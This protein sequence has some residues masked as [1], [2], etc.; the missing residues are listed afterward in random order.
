MSLTQHAPQPRLRYHRHAYYF[1][2]EALRLA[3][4]LLGRESSDADDD[5]AHITGRELLDGVRVLGLRQF[6]M[7]APVVFAHWGITTTDDFGQIVFEMIERE[8]LRKTER[9]QVS[10]FADVYHFDDVFQQNYQVDTSKA[11]R[12]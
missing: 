3:Q 2:T 11:F 10:D 7:M 8:E 1:V 9:D 4:E 6:G 5:S 12:Q